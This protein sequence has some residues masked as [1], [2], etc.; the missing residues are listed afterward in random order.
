MKRAFN[1]T[2]KT[3]LEFI[4]DPVL[5]LVSILFPIVYILLLT[6][7]NKSWGREC[8]F[9]KLRALIPGSMVVSSALVMYFMAA[10]VSKDRKSSL[11]KR[12]YVSPMR[13][14]E[15]LFGYVMLG[16]VVGLVQLILCDIFGLIVAAAYHES[17]MSAGQGTLLVLSQIPILLALIFFGILLGSLL[18]DKAAPGVCAII[19]ILV[20]LLGGCFFGLEAAD[21]FETFARCLPFYPSVYIGRIIT[22]AEM[23]PPTLYPTQKYYYEWN[24]IASIG[25]GTIFIYLAFN[26][27]L[28]NVVFTIQCK[29]Q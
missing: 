27:T 21:E 6:F 3:F 5:T 16:I 10:L 17:Y 13:T 20:G 1:F 7:I 2:R 4:K 22:H 26:V 25:L 23:T 8:E 14:P 19:L 15:F 12:L 11:L 9:L 28:A 24:S 29:K 18:N